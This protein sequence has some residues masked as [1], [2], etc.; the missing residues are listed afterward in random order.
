MIL[1]TTVPLAHLLESLGIEPWRAAAT[2]GLITLCTPGIFGFLAWEFRENWKLYK[3]NRSKN[4]RPIRVGSHGETLATFLRPGFHSG[5][6]PKIFHR[7]R[8]AQLRSSA[9][10]AADNKH[11]HAAHHVEH[12][13][14]AFFNREFIALLN[15]HPLFH[16]APIAL[17]K[18]H[19]ATTLIRVELHMTQSAGMAQANGACV[20]PLVL[21]FEQRAGWILAGVDQRGW[22]AGLA[23]AQSRQF[24]GALLGL[25]KL[26]GVDIVR[27]Q[28]LSLFG[29]REARFDFRR[30]DLIVWPHPDFSVEGIYDLSTD[31]AIEPRFTT[32]PQDVRL[33]A[34][35]AEQILFRGAPVAREGWIKLWES[36][37]ETPLP[38]MRV[39]G[40]EANG[41]VEGQ[42]IAPASS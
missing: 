17:G 41:T 38:G 5:T 7:L 21:S 9:A 19:L 27:E 10:L 37:A 15:R 3:A 30:N 28:V 12:S 18:I 31:G 24:S 42:A 6:I 32:S 16:D 26:S 1:P 4:L 8:K 22:S 14:A 13:L 23:D 34:L 36:Q 25:Y 11:I 2:A 33:P 39:L 20:T 35:S 29:A 40:A